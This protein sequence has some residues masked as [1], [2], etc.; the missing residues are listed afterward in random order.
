MSR[1]LHRTNSSIDGSRQG[2]QSLWLE[3]LH[4]LTG[5]GN[6][7]HGDPVT[8]AQL[9]VAQLATGQRGLEGVRKHPVRVGRVKL[10]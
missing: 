10:T 4:I 6:T 1:R 7:T 8:P 5:M 9:R 3:R 2:L